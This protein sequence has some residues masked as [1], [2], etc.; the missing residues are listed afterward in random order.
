ME[1]IKHME[2][3][4]YKRNYI[5]EAICRVDFLNPIF[6]LS[7]TLPKEFSQDIAKKFPIAESQELTENNVEILGS[8]IKNNTIKFIE[9]RF[10]NKERTRKITLK[11]DSLSLLQK[12][13]TNYAEFQE[14]FELAFN[15]LSSIY[16]KVTYK[17]FG[18]RYINNLT[19]NESNPL[20]WDKYINEKL[21]ASIYIPEDKAK[22]SRTFHN[23][24]MNFDDYNLRFNF[25]IFNPDYPARI[26]QKA[27]ILDLDAYNTS[28]QTKDEIISS[29]PILHQKIQ[30]F[31]ESSIKEEFK[32]KYLNHE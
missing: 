2:S 5:T 23:L 1:S 32:K 10:W 29:L 8:D 4:C 20:N 14:E 3:I 24:E 22:I 28:I 11:R 17:R 30:K 27:F 18:V 6:E 19:I 12:S 31:F 9:W 25:G 21:L 13:Y 16:P 26:K 7:D 15:A